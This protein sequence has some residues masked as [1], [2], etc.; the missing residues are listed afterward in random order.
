MSRTVAM[1]VP[2][3]DKANVIS[4]IAALTPDWSISFIRPCCAVDPVP[5]W[6]T[7]PTHWYNSSQ[8]VP[9]DIVEAWTGYFT[10]RPALKM[11]TAL[12]AENAYGW[13]VSNLASQGLRFVPDEE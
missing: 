10:A 6:E 5:T 3:A 11:F 7:P 13:A 4:D 1:L 2:D 12:N 9:D 8:V